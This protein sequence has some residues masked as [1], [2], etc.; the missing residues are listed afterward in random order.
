MNFSQKW[1][2]WALLALAI[3]SLVLFFLMEFGVIFEDDKDSDYMIDL[4]WTLLGLGCSMIVGIGIK[5]ATSK[6]VVKLQSMGMGM[7]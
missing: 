6:K 2:V 3:I 5:I 4:K 7:Y 1:W